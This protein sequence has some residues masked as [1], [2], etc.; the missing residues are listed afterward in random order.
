[1]KGGTAKTTTAVNLAAYLALGGLKVLLIDLDPQN[2]ATHCVGIGTTPVNSTIA[3]VLLEDRPIQ[4]AIL[5]TALPN[6][7]LVPADRRLAST[8]VLLA[9]VTGRE[10]ILKSRL[11]KIASQ[12]DH[13]L[14]D[15]PPSLN[16]LT[17]NALVASRNYV[18]TVSP[19]FLS[20]VGLESLLE[21]VDVIKKNMHSQVELLGILPTMADLRLKI[22]GE[23]IDLLRSH[24]NGKVFKTV[25]RHNV[26]LLEAPSHGKTI[27]EYDSGSMGALCYIHFGKE[28]LSRC[29]D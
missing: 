25:I 19:S 10:K 16:L 23:I 18:I 14:L 13:I 9:D 11:D 28:F 21:T 5:S 6:L 8:D 29:Q 26:K 24:F 1:M 7:D 3:D 4:D 22:T 20:L 12:Y 2:F 17:I 27:F 15:N